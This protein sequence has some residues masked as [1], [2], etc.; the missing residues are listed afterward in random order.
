[1]STPASPQAGIGALMVE[2]AGTPTDTIVPG[3]EPVPLPPGRS[4]TRQ[5]P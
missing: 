5:R 3:A 1:M 4:R 2:G